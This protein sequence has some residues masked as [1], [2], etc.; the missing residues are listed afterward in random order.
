VAWAPPSPTLAIATDLPEQDEYEV[1]IV[2]IETKRL[3]AAV[4]IVS[5][6]NKDR[7][8]RR[9]AFVTHPGSQVIFP[10]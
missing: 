10:A 7:P 6:A 5:P 2:E 3:V 9:G 1:R 8:D 4:E